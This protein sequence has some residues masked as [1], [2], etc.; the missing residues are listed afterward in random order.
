MPSDVERREPD[1]DGLTCGYCQ[2]LVRVADDLRYACACGAFVGH[3]MSCGRPDDDLGHQ[4]P[5]L[6]SLCDA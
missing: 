6:C 3:C 4:Q 1:L 5:G 2:A